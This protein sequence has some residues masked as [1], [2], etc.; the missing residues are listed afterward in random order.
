MTRLF[1]VFMPGC[2][3]CEAVKPV[4]KQFRDARPDVKVIPLDITAVEWKASKW[5]PQVTPTLVRLDARGRYTVFDGH[6]AEDGQG[7]TISP[8]EVQQWL[9]QSF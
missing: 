8:E 7:R 4:V 6:P 9:Q 2:P 3:T 5:V 1:F